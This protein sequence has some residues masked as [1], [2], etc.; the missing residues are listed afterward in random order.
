MEKSCT[1]ISSITRLFK[2]D[3]AETTVLSEQKALSIEWNVKTLAVSKDFLNG[4]I[5][6]FSKHELP[7]TATYIEIT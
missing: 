3:F 2:I 6:D 1:R 4:S 7:L 5:N